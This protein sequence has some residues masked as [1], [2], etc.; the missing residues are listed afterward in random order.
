M[1]ASPSRRA[2]SS[3]PLA[4]LL[5][6]S[7]LAALSA[8]PA[9]GQER[10]VR[11][12]FARGAVTVAQME[13]RARAHPHVAGE[14]VVLVQLPGG[15]AAVEP[16][17]GAID[18]E[19]RTGM[20]GAGLERHLLSFARSPLASTA[21]VLV[22]LN[23]GDV[24]QAMRA[25]DGA[26]DVLWSSPNFYSPLPEPREIIPNDPQYGSQYH[27][28]LM[29]NHLAWDHTL[30]IS[31]IQVAVT[32]DGV[33][34]DHA[35]LVANVWTNPGETAG[36]GID[37][38]AN[39]YIDDVHGWD[40][41]NDHNNPNPD[42]TGDDHGTHCAGIYGART[43][44]GVGV[45]GTAGGCTI[46]PVQFYWSSQPW[47][48]AN[49]AEA[50][51]YAVDNGSQITTTSYN[52]DTWVGDPVFTAGLQY[53]YDQG[54]MHFNSA[55]NGG[56]QDPPRQVF[57]QTMLVVSTDSADLKSSF[58]NWGSGVEV[59]APGSSVLSTI[60]N[61]AYGSKSGTS[62]ASPNAAGVAALI[63]SQNP[64]WS[65]EQVAA[66][67]LA[68]ADDIDGNNPGLEGLLGT[69]RVNANRA[70]TETVGAPEVAAFDGI[71]GESSV[72]PSSFRVEFDQLMEPSTVDDPA[73]YDLRESGADGLFD[74]GDD[75]IHGVTPAKPY[76]LGT[77][78]MSYDIAGGPLSL[79]EYRLT[80]VSGGLTNPF[81]TALDGDG[82]GFGG[83]DFVLY[84]QVGPQQIEPAGSLVYR[85]T[86]VASIDMAAEVDEYGIKLDE[87]QTLGVQVTGRDG[88]SPVLEVRDPGGSLVATGVPVGASLIVQALPLGTAGAYEISVAGSGGSTGSYDLAVHLNALFE[89]EAAGAPDNDSAV[90]AEDLGAS[91]FDLGGA[92]TR[93]AVVGGAGYGEDFESGTL[94]SSWTLTS[95]GPEGRIQL[96][97]VYGAASGAF[98]MLMDRI[99]SGDYTLNEA[100]WTVDLSG[101]PGALLHFYHAEWADEEDALPLSFVGSA[102]GDGVSISEDGTTWH[103]VFNPTSQAT[104][105]WQLVSIDLAAAAS[106]AGIT[107]GP[108]FGIKFQQYDNFELTT[109]GRG[110][111]A[112]SISSAGGFEDWYR[113][114]LADGERA[115]LGVTA[116]PSATADLDLVASDGVTV[117][118]SGASAANLSSV[119]N[120]FKDMTDDAAPETYFAR[121]AASGGRYSL[122]VTRSAAF[123]T[124]GNNVPANAQ[125]LPG[126]SGAVLGYVASGNDYY[127]LRL[128]L[129]ETFSL[130]ASLPAE[131]PFQFVNGLATQSGSALRMELYDPGQ[132]LV[133]TGV[134]TIEH[135]ATSQGDYVLRV[136]AEGGAGGEY[137][138]SRHGTRSRSAQ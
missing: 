2:A 116:D 101:V 38:D 93:L 52:I 23:G 11:D 57:E 72:P 70:L 40:F 89:E 100:V 58:S 5:F 60:L 79:G 107:L 68:T 31:S 32:D 44:N 102:N 19:G 91:S 85:W 81:G 110:Y 13:E 122:L 56:Q 105:V 126:L 63:W 45:A 43:N 125:H 25:L 67:L 103:R 64:G 78:E 46:L 136:Y 124:E 96:S 84:F 123:D 30:G 132:N 18:W 118:A 24:F 73:S 22:D 74:T 128:H 134:D 48:A 55:G 51:A 120:D 76:M 133:A 137:V 39:G 115:T 82:D 42:S 109:D 99:P 14:V 15:A 69:G 71:A 97:D 108:G 104:G 27:H 47:T 106:N 62:M 10:A 131:G 3:P 90:A 33:D 138:L 50:Y 29:Q 94:D 16:L 36:D 66:Q 4:R 121:V 37:N 8:V 7:S 53:L 6:C 130:S 113:F 119:I 95:S 129:N 117:L 12:P 77:N 41:V 1:S 26:P 49:I 59:C 111:D 87:G 21:L 80:L 98:A 112:I 35:D 86:T 75:V 54:G 65:R 92:A 135:L 34:T 83:D 28:P 88:F 127:R 114:E 17:L 9:L 20:A 61:D